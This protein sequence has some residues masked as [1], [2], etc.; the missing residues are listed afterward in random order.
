MLTDL[1]RGV[2]TFHSYRRRPPS[3]GALSLTIITEVSV[4]S[5]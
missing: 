1:K 5:V 3:H 4:V 2:R